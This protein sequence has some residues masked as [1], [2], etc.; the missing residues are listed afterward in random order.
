MAQAAR[1]LESEA[2]QRLLRDGRIRPRGLMPDCSNY[3]YLAQV[4]GPDG[5]QT[6]AVYKPA[7]GETPLDDFPDGTLG[8]REVAAYLV[9]AALGWNVVPLTVYRA[10][11]PHGPGSL[12]QFIV[13]DLREHYFSLMPARASTFRT[14]AAFDVIVN[15]ADR[16]SGHCLLDREGHIW[17]VDNGLTFHP[18]PKLRT[19]IWEFGG[20]EIPTNLRQDA[21]RLAGELL[22]GRGWVKELRT[23]ITGPEIRALAQ[24]ARR[25]ADGG[26]YPEPSSRW[27]YPWPLI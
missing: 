17:G 6:L 16:K 23:L 19:V 12:Q 14:M 24:R 15:N 25:V 4:N 26:R 7:Q 18:L 10:D 22:A 3:T 27:A 13:A 21:E 5:T 9:S 11:G 1:S 20:E 2:Q 8:K